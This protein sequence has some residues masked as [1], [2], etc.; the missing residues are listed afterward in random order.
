ML[1]PFSQGLGLGAGL[2]IAIGAQNAFVLSQGVKRNHHFTVALI[3]AVCDAALILAG[4]MGLGALVAQNPVLLGLAA[5]GGAGFLAWHGWRALR[6][7]LQGG[8]LETDQAAT[9]PLK[10]VILATLAVTLLNPHVYLDTVVLL[11]SISAQF[12]GQGRYYFAAGAVCASFAWF[13]GLSLGG[14][15]MAPLLRNIWAWRVLDGL[16]CLTM[17]SIAGS[18]VL[19]ALPD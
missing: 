15:L 18:L 4:V 11:G 19:R 5:W 9:S 16:V 13:F 6:S 12:A 1:M 3:C 14:R 10:P 7:A 17:W 8:R 2:I